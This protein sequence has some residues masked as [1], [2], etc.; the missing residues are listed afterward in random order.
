MA[1]AL[2]ALWRG[3]LDDGDAR[4]AA[5]EMVAGRP[6][7][8]RETLR[9]EVPQAALQAKFG[10]RLVQELALEL[11]RISDAGLARLPGSE[12]DRRLLAPLWGYASAGRTPA[13]DMLDDFAAAKGD[14]AKLVARWEL[15]P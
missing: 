13:D 12:D 8:E 10:G 6:F 4:A 11:I 5:W 14:P 15:K 9:R 1:A 3:L 2:G 7:T